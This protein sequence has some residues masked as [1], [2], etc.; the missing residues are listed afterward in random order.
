MQRWK[1]SSTFQFPRQGSKSRLALCS[2]GAFHGQLN[3]LSGRMIFETCVIPILLYDCE[4]SSCKIGGFP[5][6]NREKDTQNLSVPLFQGSQAS[7]QLALNRHPNFGKEASIPNMGNERSLSNQFFSRLLETLENAPLQLLEGCSFLEAHLGLEGIVVRVKDGSLLPRK[8]KD[9]LLLSDQTT[10][11]NNCNTHV[12]SNL[13]A[14]IATSTNWLK[15]W[16]TALDFGQRGTKAIQ[17][18]FKEMT[19]PVFG[20]IPCSLCDQSIPESTPYL[21]HCACE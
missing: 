10:L 3:P 14:K 4:F 17:S 20:N 11:L 13:A 1:P 6:R 19:R 16:D 15:I 7:S 18:L 9:E 5:G 2:I 12:S 8:I 21:D